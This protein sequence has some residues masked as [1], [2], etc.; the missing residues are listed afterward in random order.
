[1]KKNV[2]KIHK[3]MSLS[4]LRAELKSLR[5]KVSPAAV[6]KM[7]KADCVREIEALK[8]L[9]GK[10][11]AME[12]KIHEREEEQVSAIAA[13]AGVPKKMA[14]KIAVMESESHG[15]EEAMTK[16]EHKKQVKAVE[17]KSRK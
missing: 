10:E 3:Q 14:K 15:M 2:A 4:E 9:H 7:K 13:K 8:R 1:M 16:K 17:K 12:K 6:S 5:R 11:E